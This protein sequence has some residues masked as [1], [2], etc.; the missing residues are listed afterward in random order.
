VELPHRGV[1]E[2]LEVFEGEQ[3]VRQFYPIRQFLF[4]QMLSLGQPLLLG[5]WQLFTRF[6]QAPINHFPVERRTQ[7]VLGVLPLLQYFMDFGGSYWVGIFK[8]LLLL[9][10]F[11]KL[12]STLVDFGLHGWRIRLEEV[13]LLVVETELVDLE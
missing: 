6:A 4:R 1:F 11:L 7:D 5:H 8:R 10:L 12:K 2:K 9:R 13:A 3:V